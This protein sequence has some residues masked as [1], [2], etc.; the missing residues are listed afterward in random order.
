MRERG[1]RV[2]PVRLWVLS[3][4]TLDPR[5]MSHAELREKIPYEIE[6]TTVFRALNALTKARLL[7]RIHVGDR[8]W[9]YTRALTTG[10]GLAGS[11]VCT[12]CGSVEELREL[13]LGMAAPPLAV[14]KS[15][16]RV[17]VHGLCDDCGP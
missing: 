2:T 9:R 4:L 12:S 16:V 15:N 1:L 7:H 17:F 6:R 13:K 14:R 11:F 3:L 10:N 5:P 8:V